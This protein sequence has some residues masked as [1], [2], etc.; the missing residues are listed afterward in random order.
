MEAFSGW[1]QSIPAWQ[2]MMAGLALAA[3]AAIA[4]Y[5]L[6]L[7]P[8]LRQINSQAGVV[9]ADEIAAIRAE[10]EK[11]RQTLAA[12][13]QQN[14][15]RLSPAAASGGGSALAT[16]AQ[17]DEAIASSG[18]LLLSRDAC[19]QPR[20]D[21]VPPPTPAM[22]QSLTALSALP[23]SAGQ[24]EDLPSDARCAS[25][26]HVAAGSFSAALLLLRRLSALAA[27]CRFES[28]ALTSRDP[29]DGRGSVALQFDAKIYF[30]H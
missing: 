18:M 15:N 11:I 6:R 30:L 5:Q 8:R 25:Y 10:A 20:D 16:L 19:L 13:R 2:R 1:W 21:I 9:S 17:I 29:G 14:R 27:P 26:R 12:L 28:L 24:A 23:P 7:A 22:R 3:A 4:Y